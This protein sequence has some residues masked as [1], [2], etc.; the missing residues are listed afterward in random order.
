M[1]ILIFTV[2][3]D[4]LCHGCY[5]YVSWDKQSQYSTSIRQSPL[6]S[7]TDM[8]RLLTPS[9]FRSRAADYVPVPEIKKKSLDEIAS[10]TWSN[11]NH[12]KGS[13]IIPTMGLKKSGE[14]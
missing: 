7:L 4:F 9:P 12:C 11:A 10:F 6:N 1:H 8:M 2:N 14:S 3:P 13:T 5:L